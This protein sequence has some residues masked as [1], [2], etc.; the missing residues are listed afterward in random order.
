MAIRLKQAGIDDFAVL[1]RA[2][3]VGG[4]WR[5]NTY[6]GCQCDVQSHLY[7]FSFAPNPD[8]SRAF[9]EQPEIWEYLRRCAHGYGIT[10]HIRFGHEVCSATW[11]EDAARWRIDTSRG[12]LSARVLVA[13]VGPLSEPALPRIPGLETFQGTRFHSADWDHSHDLSGER[14]AVIGTGASAVQLVP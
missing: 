5:D 14:V 11:D 7:S 1:E 9:S 3:D 6:P 8:W 12:A 4:T 10:G 13:G 2:G